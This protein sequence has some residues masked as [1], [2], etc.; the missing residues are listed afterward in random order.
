MN[1]GEEKLNEAEVSICLEWAQ[2]NLQKDPA[3][4][5]VV[6]ELCREWFRTREKK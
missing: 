3:G 4:F 2:R 1:K 6:A 5:G